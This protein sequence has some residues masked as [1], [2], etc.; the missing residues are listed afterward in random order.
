MHRL[1][2]CLT[3]FPY[4]GPYHSTLSD[5][6]SYKKPNCKVTLYSVTCHGSNAMLYSSFTGVICADSVASTDEMW[7]VRLGLT[8]LFEI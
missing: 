7:L 8:K 6:H 5:V 3:N 2:Q 1:D 4:D